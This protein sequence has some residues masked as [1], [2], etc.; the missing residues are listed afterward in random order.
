VKFAE[1]GNFIKRYGQ[2]TVNKAKKVIKILQN[3]L[4][5]AKKYAIIIIG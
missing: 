1:T 3:L 2:K 5:N 4:Q